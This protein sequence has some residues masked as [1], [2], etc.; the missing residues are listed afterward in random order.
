MNG[1]LSSWSDVLSVI[2]QGSVL[3]PL[4]FILFINDI[5]ESLTSNA[6]LFADNTK[7]YKIIEDSND[8]GWQLAVLQV[9]S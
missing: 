7:L 3:G 1:T 6:Y 4:L 8:T 2:T 9:A 5:C